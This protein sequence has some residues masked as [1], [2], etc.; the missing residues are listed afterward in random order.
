[1]FFATENADY[2]DAAFVEVGAILIDNVDGTKYV[3]A[4]ANTTG[5]LTTLTFDV[6]VEEGAPAPHNAITSLK[7]HTNFLYPIQKS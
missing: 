5:Y 6:V 3:V 4:T 2:V 7:T 1:M